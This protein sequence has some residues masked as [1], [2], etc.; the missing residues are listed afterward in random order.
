MN[1]Q[2]TGMNMNNMM[3]MIKAQMMTMTMVSSMN[4]NNKNSDNKNN[5]NNF[6]NVIYIFIITG[7]IDFICKTIFPEVSKIILEYYQSNLKSS[8]IIN[9]IITI[10]DIKTKT[11]S[12]SITILVKI[13]DHNKAIQK[14]KDT[15]EKSK[16]INETINNIIKT[17][18][19]IPE[20]PD[21]V[22]EISEPI[23][24]TSNNVIETSEPIIGTPVTSL[25]KTNKNKTINNI[26]DVPIDNLK[27]KINPQNLYYNSE[28]KYDN[29]IETSEHIIETSYYTGPYG[30]DGCARCVGIE[31]LDN[32]MTNYYSLDDNINDTKNYYTLGVTS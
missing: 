32:D 1:I 27:E 28:E 29:V 20:T 13:S 8:K 6:I 10:S 3:E 11:K 23:N 9:N 22:I 17:S 21:N 31:S 15:I 18:E 25:S 30:Y 12:A 14:I 4:G 26:I 5:D 16:P 7:V 2:S 24:E 19:H